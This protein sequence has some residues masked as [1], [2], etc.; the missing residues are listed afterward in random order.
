MIIKEAKRVLSSDILFE[1]ILLNLLDS[2]DIDNR[3]ESIKSK[4]DVS[5]LDD[6]IELPEFEKRLED[7]DDDK[8]ISLLSKI[9]GAVTASTFNR[10]RDVVLN[11]KPEL[12]DSLQSM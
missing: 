6:L 9:R 7:L 8:V 11:T 1:N 2:E 3:I 10:L 12:E 4:N 5:I